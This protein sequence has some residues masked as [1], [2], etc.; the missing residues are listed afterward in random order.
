[1][2]LAP[3]GGIIADKVLHSTSK[4]LSISFFLLAICYAGVLLLNEGTSSIV[5]VVYSLIPG[6]IGLM[7]Y[8]V[9]FSVVSEAGVPRRMTGTIIGLTS[10]I[11]YLP[12]FFYSPM[13]GRW[14]DRSGNAGYNKIFLFL[15]GSAFIG[16][17]LSLVIYK[18]SKKDVFDQEVVTP[19]QTEP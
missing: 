3:I 14:I 5:A 17:I 19:I 4:W 16:A 18:K 1:M 11:G 13:F 9:I 12:D 2:L 7:M 8:G 15:A 6:A 10:I